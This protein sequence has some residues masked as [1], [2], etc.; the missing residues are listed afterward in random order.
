MHR[1]ELAALPSLVKKQGNKTENEWFCED[2]KSQFFFVVVVNVFLLLCCNS[3]G[4]DTNYR[5]GKVYISCHKGFDC[6]K[7]YFVFKIVLVYCS[8]RVIKKN[9]CKFEFAGGEFE[10]TRISYLNSESRA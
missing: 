3:C 8:K 4:F 2:E 5:K 6:K 10:I 1:S 9:F 7:W